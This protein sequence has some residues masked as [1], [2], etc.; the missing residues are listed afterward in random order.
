MWFSSH[1]EITTMGG[2]ASSSGNMSGMHTGAI[3]V[4]RGVAPS[5]EVWVNFTRWV[6][7]EEEGKKKVHHPLYLLERY[8]KFHNINGIYPTIENGRYTFVRSIWQDPLQQ[9]TIPY[10]A[11]VW[12]HFLRQWGGGGR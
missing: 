8:A 9:Q 4:S 3:D 1:P 12:P 10:I 5:R 7:G 2:G 6:A 11:R